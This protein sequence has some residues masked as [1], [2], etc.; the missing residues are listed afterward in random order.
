MPDEPVLSSGGTLNFPSFRDAQRSPL[1]KELFKVEGVTGVFLANNFITV[2][3]AADVEWHVLKP[4]VFSTIT[5][6]YES[7]EP[8]VREDGSDAQSSANTDILE[9]D[10]EVVAM[11]K[12]LLET[13]VRPAVQGDGG[14]IIYR[15]FEDGIVL[16]QLQG[17]CDGCPSSAITL[18]SGIERMLMHWVRQSCCGL[19]EC[20]NTHIVR[21][22]S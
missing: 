19:V 10:D 9:D 17:S 8:V 6:F 16:L 11:I 5:E 7:G 2:S 21:A 3:K 18:K 15:G 14:D 22:L 4:F 1:A 13:R 20:E 12:E